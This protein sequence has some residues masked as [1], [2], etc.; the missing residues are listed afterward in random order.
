MP[1]NSDSSGEV[2]DEVVAALL[3]YHALIEIR[4]AARKARREPEKP[5]DE[6]LERISFLSDLVHNLPG[7]IQSPGR[8]RASLPEHAS[9]RD[10]ALRSRPMSWTWNTCGPPGQEWMLRRI[11]EAGYRW[12]P[13]PPLPTPRK[14]AVEW[15]L[16]LRFRVLAGWP[17]HPPSGLPGL[18]RRA[19]VLKALDRDQI[20]ALYEE[21]ARERLGQG[22]VGLDYRAHLDPRAQQYIFPD[23][24]A[25]N[26]PGEDRPW[27]QSRVLLS[28]VD[29]EQISGTLSVL[30]ETFTAL[31]SA[32]PRIR[33]RRLALR[34]RMLER[35]YY[36][37]FR[38][39][40]EVCSPQRCGYPVKI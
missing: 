29:G 19:R 8:R 23:P 39:H 3:I 12:T 27:W 36:L 22:P 20:C 21:A 34:A 26:W 14:G 2:D 33:Q 25:Y 31:P 13:P 18:P 6:V 37:W 11:A 17:V 24:A 5:T 4:Y 28:M 32:V 10:R 1:S 35:D 40:E 30:P 7:K 9:R 16:R 38:D 15:S